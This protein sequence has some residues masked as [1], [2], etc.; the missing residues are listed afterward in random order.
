MNIT[1]ISM[2]YEE[3]KTNITHNIK[4]IRLGAAAGTGLVGPTK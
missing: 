1:A 2:G 3:G 4:N